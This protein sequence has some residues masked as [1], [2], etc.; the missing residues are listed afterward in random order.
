M[1]NYKHN[2]YKTKLCDVPVSPKKL[3][4]L[5]GPPLVSAA[6]S[7]TIRGLGPGPFSVSEMLPSIIW[8]M[9]LAVPEE[10]GAGGGAGGAV[11]GGRALLW[12]SGLV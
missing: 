5:K 1:F 11:A 10:S 4:L 3:I 9:I 7:T 2:A 12:Q 8:A 6:T